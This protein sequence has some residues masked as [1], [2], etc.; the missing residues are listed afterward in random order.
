MGRGSSS[1]APAPAEDAAAP[2]GAGTDTAAATAAPADDAAGADVAAST[3]RACRAGAA[4][5]ATRNSGARDA[6]S[7]RAA[8]AVAAGRGSANPPEQ[9][10]DAAQAATD[11]LARLTPADGQVL[12]GAAKIS[13]A[14]APDA[15][16][17]EVWQ[18]EGCAKLTG[19]PATSATHAGDIRNR[20]PESPNCIYMGGY[21]LGPSNPIKTY[22]PE[23]GLWVRS[24]AIGDGKDTVVLTVIDGTS[25][26]GR[27]ANMCKV[28]GA[29]DLAEQLS[30]ELGI[31]KS[32]FF[33]AS[34][35]SHTAP[36]F[37]GGWGG[38]PR[39]YSDQIAEAMRESVRQAVADMRPAVLENGEV[40]ARSFNGERRDFYRSA[41][42]PTLGWFRALELD[43]DGEPTGAAIATVGAYAAHP[44][45]VDA[46]PGIADADFPGVFDKRL[47]E[48]FGGVGL[49]FMTGLGNVSPR[50]NKL[51]M[52]NGLAA[53]VPDIGFGTPVQGSDVR[54]A[55]VFYD[56]PV[57]NLGLTAL[58]TPGFFDRPLAQNPAAISVGKD[59]SRPCRSASPVSVRT[60]VS[61]A[62]VGDLTITGAPGETFSNLSA[63]LKERSPGA[64]TLPL[65]QVND[66][67]GYIIQS[68][69]T[70]HAGRQAVGFVGKAQAGPVRQGLAE[71]EDA[72]SMDACFG[73]MVLETTIKLISDLK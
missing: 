34:T 46:G 63:T 60:A 58:G 25:Y 14:P 1:P 53:L 29:F 9:A 27:Y 44:V 49:Y 38:V 5:S 2:A 39:W 12:A 17:G 59:A 43:E 22:D 8:T 32:A 40:I 72:Y 52:G 11:A 68:F 45:T 36:D 56:Q 33:F 70:D 57:T 71:Y 66:G 6:A 23:Y 26:F 54:S 50:G 73:D 3:R 10:A 30:A 42:D 61:A 18:T 28:C 16:K 4:T 24:V 55:Q 65:G 41:E 19:D 7:T 47:E 67:L 62:K 21:G 15:A 20:F 51:D 64:V 69:E 13:M 48:R 35:H 37:L 31:D